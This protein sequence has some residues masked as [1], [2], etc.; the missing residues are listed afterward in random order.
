[1]K[2]FLKMLGEHHTFPRHRIEEEAALRGD[3]TR[4]IRVCHAIHLRSSLEA[5]WAKSFEAFRNR[6][7]SHATKHSN[8]FFTLS[9]TAC[10]TPEKE[11]TL[12][13]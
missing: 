4:L 1:M 9:F 11:E 8:A 13:A 12:T 7:V 6:A 2:L 3:R 5:G 10:Q